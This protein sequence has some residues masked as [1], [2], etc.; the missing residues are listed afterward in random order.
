MTPDSIKWYNTSLKELEKIHRSYELT[1]EG[2]FQNCHLIRWWTKILYYPDQCSEFSI[3]DA[4]FKP[5]Y[6]YDYL[7]K[8]SIDWQ[9]RSQKVFQEINKNN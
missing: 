3:M 7:M 5:E 4:E 8:D 1:Y 6:Q 2:T 9:Y